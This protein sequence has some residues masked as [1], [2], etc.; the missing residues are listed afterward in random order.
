MHKYQ[1]TAELRK[2][3]GKGVARKLRA[4][5][6]VPAIAYGAKAEAPIGLAVPTHELVSILRKPTG[7]FSPIELTVG[8]EKL[9]VL[10]QD[11]QVDPLSRALVH[12][13]FLLV[14]ENEPVKVEVPVRTEGKSKGEAAGARLV[15]AR[16]ELKVSCLPGLIPTEIVVDVRPLRGGEVLYVDQVKYPEGVTPVYKARYPV[17]VLM[18]AKGEGG[19]EETEAGEATEAAAE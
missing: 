10:V 15:V 12:C 8:N 11:I 13:D 4:A 19:D 14:N 2:D 5:G 16:R 7:R 6:K 17:I 18:K 1:L 3:T 9:S